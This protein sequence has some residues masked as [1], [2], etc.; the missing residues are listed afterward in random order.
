[1]KKR[2]KRKAKFKA[3]KPKGSNLNGKNITSCFYK[4]IEVFL[5]ILFMKFIIGASIYLVAF[6]S[7]KV[8]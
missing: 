5:K 7:F 4:N 6:I 2:N 8:L 1:M 3:R